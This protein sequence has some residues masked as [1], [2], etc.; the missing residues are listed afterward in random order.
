MRE[1]KTIDQVSIRFTE[2]RWSHI[3]ENHDDL[4]DYY[5]EI[6]DTIEFPEFIIK[7]YNDA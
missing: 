2:E 4:A 5:D 1:I 6:I 7:G 3:K